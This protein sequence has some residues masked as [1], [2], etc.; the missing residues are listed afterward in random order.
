MAEGGGQFAAAFPGVPGHLLSFLQGDASRVP[1][2]DDAFEVVTCQTVLMHL[3]DPSAGLREMWRIARPGGLVIC[4]EPG[5]LWNY[6]PFTS[7][8]PDEP[9]GSLVGQF[10]FW[11]R[12]HRG[13]IALGEGDHNLG[14]RLPGLF[15]EL[16]FED[17]AV[18][19]SDRVPALFP[20]YGTPAQQALVQEAGEQASAG[21]GPSERE[22]LRRLFL[23]GG[24]AGE[25]FES[26]YEAVVAGRLQQAR[27]I[28]DGTFHAGFGGITY[29]VSGRK[30]GH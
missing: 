18:Y 23:A 14:D 17:I 13:R 5:N 30:P 16:G 4:V 19:Q 6:L 7:L 11:L 21:R 22:A 2:P 20:P 15:A 3:P 10:E 8:T 9:T 29:L 25:A 28:A 12:C 27:G 26:M 24:G 1:L